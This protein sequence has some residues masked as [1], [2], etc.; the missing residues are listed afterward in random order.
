MVVVSLMGCASG[1][2]ALPGDENVGEQQQAFGPVD[3]IYVY[4][5][6][7]NYVV[8]ATATSA[9]SIEL[10][11]GA[12]SMGADSSS[13]FTWTLTAGTGTGSLSAK[14]TFPGGTVVWYNQLQIPLQSSVA[15]GWLTSCA[16]YTGKLYCWGEGD[17]GARGSGGTTDSTTPVQVGTNKNIVKVLMHNYGGCWIDQGSNQQVS[18]WGRNLY[19]ITG[20]DPAVTTQSTAPVAI[21]N[22]NQGVADLAVG[23]YHACLLRNGDVYCW[24]RGT[25]GQLGGNGLSSSYALIGPVLTGVAKIAAGGDTTCAITT[26]GTLYC[27]GR[28]DYGQVGNGGG[29]AG[30]IQTP[31]L[32]AVLDVAGVAVGYRHTCATRLNGTIYCWGRNDAGQLMQGSADASNHVSPLLA[33]YSYGGTFGGIFSGRNLDTCIIDSNVLKCVGENMYGEMGNNTTSAYELTQKTATGFTSLLGSYSLGGAVALG[34][35]AGHIYAWGDNS[36]GEVGNASASN[37]QL[38]PIQV[39]GL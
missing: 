26:T 7:N 6:S 30:A 14:A 21:A 18:C 20:Q 29:A 12:S 33:A 28:D 31:T 24:G 8:T 25:S 34:F 27:W 39:T 17:Y 15:G 10:F 37:P 19:G 9:T 22:S 16:S 35:R 32:I 1:S 13:P 11:W 2:D 38:T 23:E 36:R 4:N 3:V 5:S